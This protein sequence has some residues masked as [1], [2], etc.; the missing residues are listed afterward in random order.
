MQDFLVNI[1]QDLHGIIVTRT[2]DRKIP[3]AERQL[4]LQRDKGLCPDEAPENGSCLRNQFCCFIIAVFIAAG[5]KHIQRIVQEVWVKL[6]L[7][8]LHFRFFVLELVVICFVDV[9]FQAFRHSVD[10]MG[11]IGKCSLI[12]VSADAVVQL[13][14]AQFA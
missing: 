11:N 8:F 4:L 1:V 2:V 5:P 7:K 14:L 13:V 3:L 6:R 10:R 12:E 9:L